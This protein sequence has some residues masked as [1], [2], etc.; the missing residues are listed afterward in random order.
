MRCKFIDFSIHGRFIEFGFIEWWRAWVN[1]FTIWSW[2]VHDGW[3]WF[4]E[5]T[6]NRLGAQKGGLKR[7]LEK[8]GQ[9][10]AFSMWAMWAKSFMNVTCNVDDVACVSWNVNDVCKTSKTGVGGRKKMGWQSTVG[11]PILGGP[12]EGRRMSRGSK[13]AFWR[14]PIGAD[15]ILMRWIGAML[16]NNARA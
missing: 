7:R 13:T 1:L 10:S 14:V 12:A 15:K 9:I 16:C 8:W 2:C 6:S 5:M 3:A 4:Y 11:A